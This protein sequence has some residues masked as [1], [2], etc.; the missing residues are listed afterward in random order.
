[1]GSR[2]RVLLREKGVTQRELAAVLHLSPNTVNGYIQNRRTPD[3]ETISRI[4]AYLDT[5][6][7]YLLG[8]TSLK[9]YPR[10]PL[11]YDEGRLLNNYRIMDDEKKHILENFSAALCVCSFTTGNA[12]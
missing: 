5:S 9:S 1:M 4:A 10:H 3:C 11:N 12:E 7:D 2:I 8:N 6:V